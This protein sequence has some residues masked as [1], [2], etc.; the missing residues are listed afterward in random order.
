MGTIGLTAKESKRYSVGRLLLAAATRDFRGAGL[1]LEAHH[2]LVEK[3]GQT[4]SGGFLVPQ[5]V[6]SRAA[7]SAG[8]ATT[9]LETVEN[10]VQPIVDALRARSVVLSSGATVLPGQV[11][12]Q[13]F[14]RALTTSA[15]GYVSEGSDGNESEATFGSFVMQPRTLTG[16]SNITRKLL[17]SAGEN[18][19]IENWISGELAQSVA[20][21]LDRACLQGSGA[22][23]IIGLETLAGLQDLGAAVA[24]SSNFFA[25]LEALVLTSNGAPTDELAYIVAPQ[26]YVNT[27]KLADSAGGRVYP[28]DTPQPIG[29]RGIYQT[30][31]CPTTRIFFVHAPS[32]LVGLWGQ[33][34]EILV[35]PYGANYAS[36]G[37]QVRVMLSADMNVSQL[38][39]VARGSRT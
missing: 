4:S 12:N 34:V 26:T 8:T 39:A 1:E 23:S 9:G 14:P 32:L 3:Q 35:N 31:N 6:F 29:G 24:L 28:F 30:A 18:V 15:V 36:G 25:D 21:A 33:G 20:V 27:K 7:Y 16:Y 37:L 2:A 11:G 13:T 17:L 5:E 38:A 22:G 10:E 19:A